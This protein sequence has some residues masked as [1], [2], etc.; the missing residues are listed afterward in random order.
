MR[1]IEGI[2]IL[3]VRAR[4][5]VVIGIGN[6]VISAIAVAIVVSHLSNPVLAKLWYLADR[7]ASPGEFL[8]WATLGGAFSGYP[9]GLIGHAL[10]IVGTALFWFL[11]SMIGAV[12][13]KIITGRRGRT[14][15]TH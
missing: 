13:V 15:I 7:F 2:E 11:V 6:I 5:I 12:L 4:T 3:V 8:W 9:T 14:K 1:Q 10:W